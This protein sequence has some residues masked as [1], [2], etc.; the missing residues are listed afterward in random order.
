MD[1]E[2]ILNEADVRRMFPRSKLSVAELQSLRQGRSAPH[3]D[4]L[5]PTNS[6]NEA[7]VARGGQ[8]VSTLIVLPRWT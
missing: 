2:Q 1:A 4:L 3:F 5:L 6:T 7:S 8:R